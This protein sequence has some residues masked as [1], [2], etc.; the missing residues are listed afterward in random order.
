MPLAAIAIEA[1]NIPQGYADKSGIDVN[2]SFGCRSRYRNRRRKE[3]SKK[4]IPIPIPIP[5]PKSVFG[6]MPLQCKITV[7]TR[8]E[9][10]KANGAADFHGS[11]KGAHL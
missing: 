6:K 9:I 8:L 1:A 3:Q 10:S 2:C 4:T 5:T 7:V 11:Q